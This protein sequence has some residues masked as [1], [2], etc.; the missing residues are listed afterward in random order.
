MSRITD[1]EAK[2]SQ[3]DYNEESRSTE[4]WRQP[5]LIRRLSGEAAMLVK[6]RD[7]PEPAGGSTDHNAGGHSSAEKTAAIQAQGKVEGEGGFRK[8]LR[9]TLQILGKNHASKYSC[10]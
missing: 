5:S 6:Q 10:R 2:S 8:G 3:D 9:N 4:E 7:G 1:K